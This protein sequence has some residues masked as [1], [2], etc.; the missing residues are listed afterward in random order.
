MEK[1]IVTFALLVLAAVAGPLAASAASLSFLPQTGSVSAG[2][3]FTVNADV[4]STDQAMNAVSATVA[5]PK[6]KLSVVSVSK[7]G[8]I[9]S[10]W[11]VDPSFSNSDGSVTFEG[12][13]LN[14]G[15]EGQNGKVV[16]ITFRA[17]SAGTAAISFDSGSVL[18]NDGVGTSL[19]TS[20]GSA[21]FTITP[22][23]PQ[24]TASSAATVPTAVAATATVATTTAAP[25]QTPCT[26]PAPLLLFGYPVT[27][28][29]L[30][31]AAL[32]IAFL[33]FIIG[34][35]SKGKGK[36]SP[37]PSIPSAPGTGAEKLAEMKLRYFGDYVNAQI[38]VLEKDDRIKTLAG[39]TEVIENIRKHIGDF[40]DFIDRE[41]Q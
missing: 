11:T 39:S 6:D 16:S 5:F 22:T 34:R 36:R 23:L 41:K 24:A 3:E 37:M 2:S 9:V 20:L 12:I 21:T 7:S 35:F 38:D 33:A 18:A 28:L 8:S 10:L 19:P 31:I 14:P 13:V 40:K 1:K 25:I 27:P 15:F 29:S 32:A 26:V 30:A 4:A 17:K